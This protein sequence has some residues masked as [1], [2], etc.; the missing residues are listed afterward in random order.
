MFPVIFPVFSQDTTTWQNTNTTR[1][2]ADVNNF[3]C[4]KGHWLLFALL[5][6]LTGQ[7]MEGERV[8]K[9]YNKGADKNQTSDA[10]AC[11]VTI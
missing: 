11:A 1:R 5:D 4:V 2:K 10:A 7:E 6:S 3:S 8:G 9:K